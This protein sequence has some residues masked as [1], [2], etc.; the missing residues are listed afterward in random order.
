MA[1]V[2]GRGC[3]KELLGF[4]KALRKR[5]TYAEKLL[6]QQLRA[7]RLDGVHFRQQ[8]PLGGFIADFYC[9][10]YRL[11]IELDGPI[12]DDKVAFDA[13]RDALMREAK[14]RIV[15]VKNAEVVQSIW[16]VL[17]QIRNAIADA[18]LECPLD[19]N[20]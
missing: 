2:G 6:W 15:R 3:S 11:V 10:R 14:F 9:A 7:N 20:D 18:K 5:R 17:N 19:S 13:T 12:H 1:R 16:S 4:A 8:E